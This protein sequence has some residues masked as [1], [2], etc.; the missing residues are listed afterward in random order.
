[1]YSRWT[2]IITSLAFPVAQTGNM[3]SQWMHGLLKC[4]KQMDYAM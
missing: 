1:M 4:Y 2:Y 3:G